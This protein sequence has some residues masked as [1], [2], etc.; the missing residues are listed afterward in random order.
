[1]EEKLKTDKKYLQI[2][3]LKTKSLHPE[4]FFFIEF[5]KLNNKRGNPIENK[6][7]T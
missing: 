3:H 1:M 5:S 4:C 6:Q 2:K 7:N